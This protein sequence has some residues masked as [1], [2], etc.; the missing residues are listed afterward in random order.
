MNKM[1]IVFI[2]H[3]KTNQTGDTPIT[4]WGLSDEGIE[5]A[6]QLSTNSDIKKIQEIWTSLQTKAIE[7]G[8]ILAK[9]NAIPIKTHDGLTEITSFTMS[10]EPDETIYMQQNN[11]IYSGEIERI[12][13]GESFEE[14]L[15]R[16]NNALEVIVKEAQREDLETIG[17]VTHGNMLASFIS[18]YYK[19]MH[20]QEIQQSL[21]MPDYA[22]FDW[23]K[24]KFISNFKEVPVSE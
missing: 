12:N 19:K 8:L 11:A 10:Y 21:K 24:K 6:N 16:F 15:K 17:V 13:N 18:Q 14:A 4:E 3:S 2:R 7:T 23:D 9:P 22:V 20:P 1:Q 5:R